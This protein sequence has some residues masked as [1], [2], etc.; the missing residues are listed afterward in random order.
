[1]Q[2]RTCTTRAS[3][4]K[5]QPR[6]SSCLMTIDAAPS[7]RQPGIEMARAVSSTWRASASWSR[8]PRAGGCGLVRADDRHHLLLGDLDVA[9]V[10]RGVESWARL[11][12]AAGAKTCG[13]ARPRPRRGSAPAGL[14]RSA[15]RH[16]T[17]ATSS[18]R[19]TTRSAPRAWAAPARSVV[20]PDHQAHDVPGLYIVDGSVV[21]SSLGVNPQITIMAMAT[22]AAAKIAAAIA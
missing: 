22:R 13:P 16:L 8:T 17:R 12:L 15:A 11:F 3:C 9:R 18:C 5:A 19:P 20:G 14:D 6:R 21:P 4:S 7:G 2:S 10:K 1:M